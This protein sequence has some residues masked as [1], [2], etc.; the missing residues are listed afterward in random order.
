MGDAI[1]QQ[2]GS[3]D[4][5]KPLKICNY[6]NKKRNSPAVFASSAAASSHETGLF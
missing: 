4:S 3:A 2:N 6:K 5:E 1:M